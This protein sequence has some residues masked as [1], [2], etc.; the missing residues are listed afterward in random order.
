MRWSY[1][2]IVISTGC[3]PKQG[4]SP[5]T[6]QAASPVVAMVVPTAPSPFEFDIRSV[7]GTIIVAASEIMDYG[8]TTHTMRWSPGVKERV[9]KAR[10]SELIGGSPFAVCVGGKPVYSGE[11]TSCFSS[12]SLNAIIILDHWRDRGQIS[13]DELVRIDIGYPNEKYFTGT[14]K[15]GDPTIRKA[16]EETGKLR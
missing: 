9:F 6:S 4:N 14:D 12:S 2:V 1:L 13:S 5:T 10:M 7:D 15:R 16:L 3:C 8:W 11:F